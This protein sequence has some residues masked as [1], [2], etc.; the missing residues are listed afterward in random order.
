MEKPVKPIKVTLSL[1]LPPPVT[2][3]TRGRA[4]VL[5]RCQIE[6]RGRSPAARLHRI[7]GCGEAWN[8]FTFP[9][10]LNSAAAT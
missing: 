1:F 9:F 3:Q 6:R 7:R 10:S 2:C 4:R 5:T 8:A